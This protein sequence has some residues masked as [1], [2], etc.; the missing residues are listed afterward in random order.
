MIDGQ[1][2][3]RVHRISVVFYSSDLLYINALTLADTMYLTIWLQLLQM[4]NPCH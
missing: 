3:M 2:L 1:Q 4:C